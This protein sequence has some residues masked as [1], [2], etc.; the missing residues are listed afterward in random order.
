MTLVE[1]D[2]SKA[3]ICL[4][5]LKKTGGSY[6]NF[7]GECKKEVMRILK[8]SQYGFCAY[9]EQKFR[10]EVFIE[11][12]IPQSHDTNKNLDFS[13]FLGVCSGIEYF[14]RKISADGT[15]HCG[16]SRGQKKL[17]IDPR[18]AEHVSTIY[19]DN[20]ANI[21]SRNLDHD[22]NLNKVLNLNFDRMSSKRNGTYN[23][24]N[25]NI[26]NANVVLK[27]PKQKVIAIALSS[28][29]ARNSEYGGYL[30]YRYS[31]LRDKFILESNQNK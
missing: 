30:K 26:I 9:C 5:E 17:I 12:F 4:I 22:D 25:T 1:I 2:K 31:E 15:H 8:E 7:G 28:L 29:N 16:N 21:R 27:L 13:N 11:H 10:S 14:H 6:S 19:Y 3:P 20:E 18:N 23:R 24:H